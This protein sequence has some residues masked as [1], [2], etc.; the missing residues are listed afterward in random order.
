[1]IAEAMN[2][3]LNASMIQFFIPLEPWL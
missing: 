3:S 2:Q 1:M